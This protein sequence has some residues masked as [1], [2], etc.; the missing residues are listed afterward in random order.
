MNIEIMLKRQGKPSIFKR[1]TKT[2]VDEFYGEVTT[3]ETEYTCYALVV[4]ARAYDIHSNLYYR[5]ETTGNEFFGIINIIITADDAEFISE[6]DFYIDGTRKY[7]II[8]SEI[9]N[10]ANSD[11]VVLEGHYESG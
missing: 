2:V 1:V 6:E 4:P 3:V 9:W 8:A 10:K 7:K 11:Y 5:P